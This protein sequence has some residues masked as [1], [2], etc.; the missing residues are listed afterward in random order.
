MK[1][2]FKKENTYRITIEKVNGTESDKIKTLQFETQDRENIFDVVDKLQ[3]GSGLEK[4]EATKLGVALRL[5]GPIMMKNRKHPLFSD[6]MPHF[7][8]FMINLKGTV[9][10][11]V[12]ES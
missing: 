3:Q 8:A 11:T 4:A 10:N 12:K 1:T 7:K 9:K 5:L 2:L 6:F